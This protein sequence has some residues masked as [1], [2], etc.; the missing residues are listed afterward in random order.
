M[1]ILRLHKASSAS[2]V[3]ERPA[4]VKPVKVKPLVNPPFRRNL[5]ISATRFVAIAPRPP[6]PATQTTIHLPGKETKKEEETATA[7]AADSQD[8][9]A[10]LTASSAGEEG[11]KQVDVSG[12]DRLGNGLTEIVAF[13]FSISILEDYIMLVQCA[14]L[15][16]FVVT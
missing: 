16:Y 5:N 6:P 7:D 1:S 14:C 9:D 8:S 4:R 13:L 2:P 15:L 11:D 3:R 12:V 10:T